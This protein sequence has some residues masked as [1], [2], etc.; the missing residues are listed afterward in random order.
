M[1]TKKN[2]IPYLAFPPGLEET[3]GPLA[4]PP[5]YCGPQEV[6]SDQWIKVVRKKKRAVR[7]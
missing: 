3:Q 7:R 6:E 4:N 2:N 1:P 5:V